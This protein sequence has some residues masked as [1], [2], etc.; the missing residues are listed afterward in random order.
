MTPKTKAKALVQ[1]IK[2]IEQGF[3]WIVFPE[4]GHGG[5][6]VIKIRCCNTCWCFQ[7][8]VKPKATIL[9]NDNHW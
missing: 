5:K 3:Q 1:T 9:T 7:I 8:A 2:N 4:G 6:T